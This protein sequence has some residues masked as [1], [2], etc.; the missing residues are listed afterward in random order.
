MFLSGGQNADDVAGLCQNPSVRA[1]VLADMDK[2][3]VEAKVRYGTVSSLLG[4]H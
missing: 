2:I 1:A 4:N 3:G